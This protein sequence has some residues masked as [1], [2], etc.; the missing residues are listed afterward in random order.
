VFPAN[1]A[2]VYLMQNRDTMWSDPSFGMLASCGTFA[3]AN[4]VA[5]QNAVVVQKVG[6][7]HEYHIA[8][9]KAPSLLE[10]AYRCWNDSHR[11]SQPVGERVSSV[12][13][14]GSLDSL[15]TLPRSL[16]VLRAVFVLLAARLLEGN[17]SGTFPELAS[18][19]NHDASQTN[20]IGI[21][22][23]RHCSR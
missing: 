12:P 6:N 22:D 10:V 14:R 4:T 3:L 19:T 20:P 7:Q 9:W 2:I 23:R 11:Q 5:K 13:H 1:L 18:Q 8:R 15:S 16:G 21:C 17:S